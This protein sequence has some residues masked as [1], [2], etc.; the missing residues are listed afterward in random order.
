MQSV[1]GK[2]RAVFGSDM[3]SNTILPRL[4]TGLD[5]FLVSGTR[6]RN[7]K[8]FIGLY[9]EKLPTIDTA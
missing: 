8:I 1:F 9:K 6:D 4:E 5:S 2:A 3:V 7:K